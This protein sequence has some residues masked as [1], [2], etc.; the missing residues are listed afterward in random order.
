MFMTSSFAFWIN[1]RPVGL[2]CTSYHIRAVTGISMRWR[3]TKLPIHKSYRRAA[4]NVRAIVRHSNHSSSTRPRIGSRRVHLICAV[5]VRADERLQSFRQETCF[6]RRR[7]ASEEELFESDEALL[8][9]LGSSG[10]TNFD[11]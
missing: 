4:W 9:H 6:A 3:T 5:D 10:R 8:I 1:P 11:A 7:S 2:K